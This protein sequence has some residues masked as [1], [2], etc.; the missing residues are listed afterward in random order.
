MT[1][2]ERETEERDNAVELSMSTELAAPD[3]MAEI[4]AEWRQRLADNLNRK[5]LQLPITDKTTGVKITAEDL[6]LLL[7]IQDMPKIKGVRQQ[8]LI[9]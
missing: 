4:D 6:K 5:R 2:T 9:R 1:E 7:T 3:N 8:K